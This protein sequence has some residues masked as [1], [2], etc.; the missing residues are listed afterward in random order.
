ECVPAR[1]MDNTARGVLLARP[2]PRA[3]R[4]PL[5]L[6]QLPLARRL[7]AERA[8]RQVARRARREHYPAPYAIIDL[9]ERFDGNALAPPAG[10]PAALDALL[11][12]PTAANLIRVFHLQERLKALGKMTAT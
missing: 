11:A 2:A 4:F 7:I 8:R 6:T 12:S 3:L 5:S 1:I 10:D 9:W